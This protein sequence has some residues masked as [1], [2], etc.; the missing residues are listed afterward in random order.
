MTAAHRAV[1]SEGAHWGSPEAARFF[2]QQ[3]VE[4]HIRQ[5]PA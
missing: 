4:P 1:R 5:L 3:F 2:W